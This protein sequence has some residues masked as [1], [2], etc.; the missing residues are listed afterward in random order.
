MTC[1]TVW[2]FGPHPEQPVRSQVWHL[3]VY[4]PMKACP[5]TRRKRVRAG[6]VPGASSG[7]FDD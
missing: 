7:A 5:V 4:E 1:A 6:G 2:R 3:A